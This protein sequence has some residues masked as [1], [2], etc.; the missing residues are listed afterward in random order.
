MNISPAAVTIYKG[1]KVG[2]ITSLSDLLM[3]DNEHIDHPPSPTPDLP[4]IDLTKSG[5]SSDQQQKL[6]TLLHQYSDLFATNEQP[7]GRASIV[8]HNNHTK[9]PPIRQPV[10]RQPV[11]LQ[12]TEVEKMLQQ[13]VIQESFSPWSSPVVM[14]KKKDGTW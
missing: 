11:A 14:V 3:V 4:N 5:L 10:R 8:K 2:N 6:F 12:D 1:T 9:G 13:G 7:L